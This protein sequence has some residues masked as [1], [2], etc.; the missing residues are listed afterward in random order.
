MS[1]YYKIIIADDEP[2]IREGLINLFPWSSLGFEIAA[3]FSN[4]Q[5][6]LNYLKDH[7]NVDVILT[8]I[9][10]PVM[11][12]I[13]LSA[14]LME[15]HTKVICFSSFQNFDYAQSAIRNHVYDYLIKPIKYEDLVSCFERLKKDLD[16][17][18]GNSGAPSL[19]SVSAPDSVIP[20]VVSYIESNYQ[21][22]TLEEA[23][24][25]VFLTPSYLSSLFHKKQG[26]TFSDYLQQVRMARAC[27]L[28]RDPEIR[29]YQIAALVGYDNPKN[30]TRAFK[31]YYQMTPQAY[32]QQMT[33]GKESEK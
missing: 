26:I 13:G 20:A 16:A 18:R 32:R 2:R 15:H 10:M 11:D 19:S 12:G 30:F 25:M 3:D 8:D 14:R 9:Q 23:A 1:D 31:A 22:C 6:V 24:S 4:G 7:D 33:G 17:E 29:Q 27:E 28:L 21:D 5:E